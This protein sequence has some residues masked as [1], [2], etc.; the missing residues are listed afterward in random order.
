MR[1]IALVAVLA[2]ASVLSIA[3][4]AQ[5][6]PSVLDEI[7]ESGVL[8]VGLTG[9]WRPMNLRDASS[10][11]YRGFD[12]DLAEAL[13]KDLG[14][15]VEIV[16]ADWPGLA[17]GLA[18]GLYHVT[19]SASITVGRARTVGFTHSYFALATVPVILKKDAEK[20]RGWRDLNR[21]NVTIAVTRGTSQERQLRRLFP[22]AKRRIVEPPGRDYDEVLAGRAD[23]HITSNVEAH[24]LVWDR[25][26]LAVV[27]VETPRAP[28]PIAMMAPRGDQ[29]WIN[30]LNTW[31][32]LQTERGFFDDLKK[33]WRIG[34]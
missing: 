19:G 11:R 6:A 28:T 4:Q 24:Q 15:K 25:P 29:V 31:I 32:A 12:V 3:A 33:R 14:A 8:K 34:G 7:L 20:F 23:A 21:P 5:S 27:S 2:L 17:Q 10:G 30:F 26:E 1:R 9:D 18:A 16:P 13:A 22:L